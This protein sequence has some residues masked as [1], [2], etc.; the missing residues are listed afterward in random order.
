MK[1]TRIYL[2]CTRTP[3]GTVVLCSSSR[4]FGPPG[5][6]LSVYS[7]V[8]VTQYKLFVLF[9]LILQMVFHLSGICCRTICTSLLLERLDGLQCIFQGIGVEGKAEG[10]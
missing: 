8:A 1:S 7:Q 3:K 9:L 6:E 5:G 4:R 10:V 2:R